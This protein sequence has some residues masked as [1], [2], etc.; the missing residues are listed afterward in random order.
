MNGSGQFRRGV[1]AQGCAGVVVRWKKGDVFH[2]PLADTSYAYGQVLRR[3]D[4][5]GT[6]CALFGRHD[7][8]PSDD[9]VEILQSKVCAVVCIGSEPLATGRWQVIGRKRIAI[10][11]TV[12]TPTERKWSR[13]YRVMPELAQ[14]LFGLMDWNP[15]L[16]ECLR[17]GARPPRPPQH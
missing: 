9:I 1:D 12:L 8:T 17:P 4:A 6:I 10:A 7:E 16:T 11:H 5:Y 2:I 14:G 13:H 15:K 3:V